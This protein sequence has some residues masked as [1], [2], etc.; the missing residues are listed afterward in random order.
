[1]SGAILPVPQYAFMAWCSV[2]A[3]GQVL[4]LENQ[5]MKIMTDKR[6]SLFVPLKL[7]GGKQN[8]LTKHKQIIHLN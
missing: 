4:L 6:G 1:M 2:K 5:L 3:Q 7:G 8:L